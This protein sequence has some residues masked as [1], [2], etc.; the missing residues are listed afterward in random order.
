MKVVKVMTSQ[1]WDAKHYDNKLGIVTKYG[2]DVLSL[3][4][5]QPN[6]TILDLGCGSGHLTAKIAESG[7]NAIGI[8]Y[9]KEMIEEARAL[10]KDITFEVGNGENF[11]LDEQVDAIFSNAALHWLKNS[12]SAVNA[13]YTNLKNG[14]RFVAEFGGKNNVATVIQA[15][16]EVLGELYDIDAKAL[17]PWYFP[18]V[19]EYAQ[20][21]EETG[22]YV[23]YVEHRDRPTPMT[24]GDQGLFHWLDAFGSVFFHSLTP[25]EKQVAYL[26]IAGKIKPKLYEDGI[27]YI[28]YKR[29]RVVAIK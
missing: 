12:H 18:S 24:D 3:L 20:L 28:D 27:W 23:K 10:Y 14:G 21:L 29:I 11:Q 9:S 17:N 26:K 16:E 6:E 7:A 19:G 5:V 25:E 4:N 13:I 22:F 15:I 8:D 1:V 2:E